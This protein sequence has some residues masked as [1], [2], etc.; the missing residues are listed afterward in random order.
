MGDHQRQQRQIQCQIPMMNGL[1]LM[2]MSLDQT[3]LS[4]KESKMLKA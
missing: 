1:L 4:L 3:E 2:T